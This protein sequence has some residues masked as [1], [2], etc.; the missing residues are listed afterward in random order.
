MGIFFKGLSM[1]I[2]AGELTFLGVAL[3]GEAGVRSGVLIVLGAEGFVPGG[4]DINR[5]RFGLDCDVL[6][7][8][9]L[10]LSTTR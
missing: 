5:G 7:G 1:F 6:P 3:L 10:A 8:D 2:R 9:G 4:D